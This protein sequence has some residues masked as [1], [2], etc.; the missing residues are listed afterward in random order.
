MSENTMAVDGFF[1]KLREYTTDESQWEIRPRNNT[2]RRTETLEC[3]ICFV[4]RMML[5]GHWKN[6]DYRNAAVAIGLD[7]EAARVI[8][9]AADGEQDWRVLSMRR[10]LERTLGLEG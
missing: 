9:E 6:P 2:I 5:G 8:A 1:R 4:A 10:Y 7:Q 3:P